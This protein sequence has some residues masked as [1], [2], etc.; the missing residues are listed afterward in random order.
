MMMNF[1]KYALNLIFPPVCGICGNLSDSYLCDKCSKY[2]KNQQRNKTDIYMDKNF[3]TH[4]WM[5]EY[6]NEIRSRIID[7]KFYDKSYL[8][9]TFVEIIIS[10]EKACEYI[11]S[12]DYL[13]PVPIHKKRLKKRGYNQCELIA[14]EICKRFENVEFRNDILIKVRNIIP[15]S[16]LDMEA[17][18][19]NV[20][21]AYEIV[22]I[23][24]L[25]RKNV[26]LFDDVFTTGSTVDECAKLIGKSSC[27]D[28]GVFT[29]AKD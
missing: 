7:Y 6:D 2:M 26:L 22:N 5:F 4:F 18:I 29:F 27:Y 24:G 15:Q 14:K 16:T 17:R 20:V 12:F 9:R 10:N 28:I 25:K 13:V 8:Y 1:I 23:E 21:G 11:N 19:N 3:T